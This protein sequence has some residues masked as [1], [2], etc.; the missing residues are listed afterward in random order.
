[1]AGLDL[2]KLAPV[3][4]GGMEGPWKLHDSSTAL[5]H[6]PLPLDTSNLATLHDTSTLKRSCRPGSPV[7][8]RLSHRSKTSFWLPD[9]ALCQNSPALAPWSQLEQFEIQEQLGHGGK[10]LLLLLLVVVGVVLIIAIHAIRAK[11]PLLRSST[12]RTWV[13]ASKTIIYSTSTCSSDHQS[14]SPLERSLR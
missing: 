8:S 7:T 12:H 14:T 4:W 9:L 6:L 11:V 1:M 10:F 5:W 2:F 13:P 3:T